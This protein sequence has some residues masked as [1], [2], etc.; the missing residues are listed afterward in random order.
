MSN[1]VV[2]VTLRNLRALNIVGNVL[3][4]MVALLSIIALTTMHHTTSGVIT[5]L[6]IATLL[7][8][9]TSVGQFLIFFY[10]WKERRLTMK[11]GSL[12]K[13]SARYGKKFVRLKKQFSEQEK[14]HSN[15]TRTI[16]Q[17]EQKVGKLSN[18]KEK[19]KDELK[20][21][22]KEI[23]ENEKQMR[24]KRNETTS[25]TKENLAL[26]REIDSNQ[27]KLVAVQEKVKESRAGAG[28]IQNLL[29]VV[30]RKPHKKVISAGKSTALTL[31]QEKPAIRV[32]EQLITEKAA[33]KTMSSEKFRQYVMSKF[34]QFPAKKTHPRIELERFIARLLQEKNASFTVSEILTMIVSVYQEADSM[35]GA[36]SVEIKKWIEDDAFVRV[37]SQKRGVR[38]Y[39]I[40]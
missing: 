25:L 30:R 28:K 7:F 24:V 36:L 4:S 16:A 22:Y 1:G 2:L 32:D 12:E 27:T 8:I 18:Q 13:Q 40:M 26:Q 31:A 38:R 21:L 17:L 10:T 3:L 11:I 14:E 9:V 6:V 29:A 5:L 35:R 15:M 33:L 39:K 19:Y 20:A 34:P 37:Q 23:S